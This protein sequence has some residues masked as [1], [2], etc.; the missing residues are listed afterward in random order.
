MKK[1]KDKNAKTTAVSGSDQKQQ[2]SRMLAR[3]QACLN[4]YVPR[5]RGGNKIST[6]KLFYIP[7]DKL[8]ANKKGLVCPAHKE[9]ALPA[10]LIVS[11]DC[12]NNRYGSAMGMVGFTFSDGEITVAKQNQIWP[13]Q[14]NKIEIDIDML[15]SLSDDQILKVVKQITSEAGKRG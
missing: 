9:T 6:L 14:K 15:S 11:E 13:K 3:C 12:L 4:D 10:G 5:G 8:E 2:A 1:K 7:N